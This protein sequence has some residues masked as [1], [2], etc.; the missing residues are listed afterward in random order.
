MLPSTAYDATLREVRFQG[1]TSL[2]ERF[3]LLAGGGG[4]G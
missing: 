3:I 1:Y 4:A 2:Y